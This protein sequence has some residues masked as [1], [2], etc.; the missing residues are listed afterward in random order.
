MDAG[1]LCLQPGHILDS[2]E[3]AVELHCLRRGP[4]PRFP[5]RRGG[6][7]RGHRAGLLL[8]RGAEGFGRAVMDADGH[9]ETDTRFRMASHSKL[10]TATAIMQL[11]EQGKIRLDD[12][13]ADY[14]P[15]FT[16]QGAA[17]DDPLITIE[18]L[19]THSSGLPRE[20]GE[21]RPLVSTGT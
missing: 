8:R 14:L 18:Q 5:A 4:L 17:P 7:L 15:W 21:N 6:C 16:F 10:F 2:G 19:L 1:Q 13:V 3:V 11:R 20:A 12:P 9:M